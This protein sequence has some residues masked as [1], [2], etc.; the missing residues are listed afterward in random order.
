MKT[1]IKSGHAFLPNIAWDQKIAI[2]ID[3]ANIAVETN[4][5]TISNAIDAKGNW[6]LPG[7]TDL[8]A[9]ICPT[10]QLY[11]AKA[12]Q[13]EL[14]AA[15]QRGITQIVVPPSLVLPT[16]DKEIALFKIGSLSQN[17]NGEVLND[18]NALAEAGCIGFSMGRRPVKDLKTLRHFYQYAA[19][20]NFKIIIEP[21]ESS[22]SQGGFIHEG[23]VSDRTGLKSI[24]ALAETLALA[25][26]LL[27]I[28]DTGIHAHFSGIS[29]AR[30]VELIAE[31]KRNGLP[32][33]A[34]TIM[35]HLHLTEIDCADFNPHC[36]VYPPLR[37]DTDRLALLKG[38]EE[39]TIDAISSYHIP[40]TSEHKAAPFSESTPGISGFDTFLSLGLLLVNRKA[41][42]LKTLIHALTTGPRQALNLP[43]P[44]RVIIVDP[45]AEWV[46]SGD[47]FLSKGHN[48]PFQGLAL[49]GQVIQVV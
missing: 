39:G 27:L 15:Y 3:D 46:A 5:N 38:L 4:P 25:Q 22:L 23:Q 36:H 26:H 42:S 40:L 29:T 49:P 30:S 21:V 31:A 43:N 14:N 19:S 37:S 13:H 34:D 28:E 1:T 48:S 6:I 32:I 17:L 11:P 44:N 24:P 2:T 33:T 9:Y 18:L 45:N 47:T 7:L 16:L 35:S 41:L 20:F 10:D 12:I 8:H